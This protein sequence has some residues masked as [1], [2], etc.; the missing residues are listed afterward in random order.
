MPVVPGTYLAEDMVM[1]AFM[2]TAIVL[3]VLSLLVVLLVRSVPSK[4]ILL[5]VFMTVAGIC[6]SAIVPS[7]ATP[8][9]VM[10]IL[11]AILVLTGLLCALISYIV[12]VFA[13][14]KA[15]VAAKS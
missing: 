3:V 11:A 7:V 5:G 4:L 9:L 12:Q 8:A 1:P 14:G 10:V 2:A 6:F 15:Q 13:S